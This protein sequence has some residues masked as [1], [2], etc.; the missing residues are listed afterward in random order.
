M[1]GP[2]DDEVEKQA[3]LVDRMP[4]RQKRKTGVSKAA[5]CR[6][7]RRMRILRYRQTKAAYERLIDRLTDYNVGWA[8]GRTGKSAGF[9]R[10][11][12][13]LIYDALH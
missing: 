13:G 11:T 6:R 5:H 3:R 2:S 12:E 10:A 7:Y 1:V 9:S 8:S 4:T